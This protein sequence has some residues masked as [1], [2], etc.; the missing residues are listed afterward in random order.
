MKDLMFSFMNDLGGSF[1]AGCQIIAGFLIG[2]ITFLSNTFI[3][4]TLALFKILL[5]VIDKD[6]I[7]HAEQVAEQMSLNNELQILMNVTKVKEDALER[8]AWTSHHSMALNELSSKLYSE[9][10]WEKDRIHDYM[11]AIVESIPG[12]SY[13]A[14]D[15]E[16][17]DDDTIG[18]DDCY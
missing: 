1:I 2:I 11:R 13:V 17:E 18:L 6:R 10:E 15:E 9:C 5:W 7:D 12:L 14:A 8:K 3:G 4:Y 16:D